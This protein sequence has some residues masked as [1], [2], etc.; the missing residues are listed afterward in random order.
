VWSILTIVETNIEKSLGNEG[1]KDDYEEV[2]TLGS[3]NTQSQTRINRYYIAEEVE[4][5]DID[6]SDTDNEVDDEP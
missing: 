5:P 3:M 4:G 2:F 6:I 1:D